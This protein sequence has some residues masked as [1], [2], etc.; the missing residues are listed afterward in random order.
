MDKPAL[1]RIKRISAP[2]RKSSKKYVSLDM[3]S[4]MVGLYS[5]VLADDLEYFEPLIRMDAS[6]NMK[7]LLPAMDQFIAEEE[8][9]KV[10]EPKAPRVIARQSEL[11]LYPSIASFVYTKMTSA[12]GLVDPSYKL[13]DHDLHVLQKL[14]NR[15]VAKRRA[16][17]KKKK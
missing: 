17:K 3:L 5:D 1:S 8:K 7:D 2:L 15:E 16:A 14:V 13:N 6:L 10:V 11:D 9:G 12:G 4:K